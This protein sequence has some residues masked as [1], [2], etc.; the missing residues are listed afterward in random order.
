[1]PTTNSDLLEMMG[2]AHLPTNSVS[3]RILP[4]LVT[5]FRPVFRARGAVELENFAEALA[6][7]QCPKALREAT[8]AVDSE[9]RGL[10]AKSCENLRS[11]VGFTCRKD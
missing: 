9:P 11:S 1:V 8:A 10:G 3:M 7:A 4:I 2:V 6:P 5:I